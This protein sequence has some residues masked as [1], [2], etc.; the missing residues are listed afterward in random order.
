MTPKSLLARLYN[1]VFQTSTKT[2][3][4]PSAG[5]DLQKARDHQKLQ[6][7]HANAKQTVIPR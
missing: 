3:A 6:K 4:A 5:V 7:W 2:D 1:T